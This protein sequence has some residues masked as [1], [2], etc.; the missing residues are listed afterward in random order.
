MTNWLQ[1]AELLQVASLHE[2]WS[3]DGLMRWLAE[4][5][6]TPGEDEAH[7]LRLESDENLVKIITMHKS[8]GLQFPVVFCPFLWDG[9]IRLDAEGFTFHD[10]GHDNAPVLDL[11]SGNSDENARQAR[12]EL[13]AENLRLAYVALTRAISRCYTVWGHIKESETSAL[14]W[15][16]HSR[17][18][19][20]E[21]SPPEGE[22]LAW[23]AQRFK[24]KPSE[25]R[26]EALEAVAAQAEGAIRIEQLPEAATAHH[27]TAETDT[28]QFEAR[29][30]S[31][32]L[33][34][35]WRITSFSGLT[36]GA[37]HTERPDYD[38][39]PP[40]AHETAAEASGIHAFPRGARA[41]SCLHELF[42]HWDFTATDGAKLQSLARRTLAAHGFDT[43]WSEVAAAMVSRVL[44]TP[45]EPSGG[46]RLAEVDIDHR[47]NEL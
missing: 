25:Y 10:A 35:R 23:L 34:T 29:Q 28:P 45:L 18:A 39:A 3:M 14:A 42:E 26:L 12:R 47:L 30:F 43:A 16:L 37:D 21:A 19:E 11:G 41:G 32:T 5:R 9:R 4:R 38:A 2:V 15:L 8:K 6:L 13:F 1:I 24:K 36:A 40:I 17:T 46:L 33:D 27:R 22:E 7:E 31:R 20:G 44:N